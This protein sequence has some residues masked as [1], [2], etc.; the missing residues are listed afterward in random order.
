MYEYMGLRRTTGKN[1]K[2]ISGGS[3][4]W[5]KDT[6]NRMVNVYLWRNRWMRGLGRIGFG[7][8]RKVHDLRRAWMMMTMDGRLDEQIVGV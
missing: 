2:C 5:D 6:K 8:M 7:M 3:I 4:G 1:G